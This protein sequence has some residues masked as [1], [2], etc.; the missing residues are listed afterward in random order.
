MK[1]ERVIELFIVII[2][3]MVSV[4]PRAMVSAFRMVLNG[5]F[6]FEKK[7][8][9]KGIFNWSPKIPSNNDS[10]TSEKPLIA[11][12]MLLEE[13]SSWKVASSD[14]ECGR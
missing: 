1:L 3:S 13:S 5:F 8:K 9:K 11:V 12:K 6:F 2:L 10:L 4:L 14:W 7:K